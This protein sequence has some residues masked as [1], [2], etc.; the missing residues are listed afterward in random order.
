METEKNEPL[1]FYPAFCFKASP[2]HFT[3]VKIGAADVHRL[4]KYG[5]F[6][7]QKVFFYNNHPVR[8]VSLL[9]IIVSRTDVYGRTI[10]ALDDSSGAIVEVIVLHDPSTKPGVAATRAKEEELDQ[11]RINIFT[12]EP[13][14]ADQ[15]PWSAFSITERNL[16]HF[17]KTTHITA[18]DHHVVDISSLQPGT[19]VRVKGVLGTFRGNMQVHLE[20]F[21]R[22]GDTN[23]EMQFLDERLRFLVEVLSVPWVLGDD[24]VESLRRAAERG[25]ERVLEEKR[26]AER[27]ARKRIEREEKDTR[28][29]AKRYEREERAREEQLGALREDGQRVMKKFGFQDRG[30]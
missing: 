12:G 7:G 4:R 5:S 11:R 3:W 26:R 2:T 17:S 24:E 8:F 29:I 25:D 19:L 10:L 28:A 22:V 30:L 23:A 18:T 6:V 14:A 13:I 9:G 15:T 1:V 27:R 21:E 16:T 20:R